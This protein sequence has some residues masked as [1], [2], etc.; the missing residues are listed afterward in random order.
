MTSAKESKTRKRNGSNS[1]CGTISLTR[2][3]G[4]ALAAVVVLTMDAPLSLSLDRSQ[5]IPSN[6][7]FSTL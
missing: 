2:E 4:L 6:S 3:N 1:C 7:F 5:L